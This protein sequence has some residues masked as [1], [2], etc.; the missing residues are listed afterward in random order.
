MIFSRYLL[1]VSETANTVIVVLAI[2]HND[3][4]AFCDIFFTDIALNLIGWIHDVLILIKF[5][6]IKELILSSMMILSSLKLIFAFTNFFVIL[7]QKFP[8]IS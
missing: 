5:Y 4:G 6:E 3:L 7:N 2:I 1:K 8:I